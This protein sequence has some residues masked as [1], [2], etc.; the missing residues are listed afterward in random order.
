M[1]ENARLFCLFGLSAVGVVSLFFIAMV[2]SGAFSPDNSTRMHEEPTPG[3][4]QGEPCVIRSESM[5]MGIG[6]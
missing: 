5:D 2:R 6:K 3:P 4:F 1:Y